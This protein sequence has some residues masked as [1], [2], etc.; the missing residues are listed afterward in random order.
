MSFQCN[1]VEIVS[2]STIVMQ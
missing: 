2:S 1:L